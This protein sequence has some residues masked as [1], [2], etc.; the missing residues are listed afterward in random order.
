MSLSVHLS[1]KEYK[2]NDNHGLLI[3]LK[4]FYVS[5]ISD[6][7]VALHLAE[8][9]ALLSTLDDFPILP[10][11]ALYWTSKRESY[12]FLSRSSCSRCASYDSS[13]FFSSLWIFLTCS[14]SFC[15][16]ASSSTRTSYLTWIFS[17]WDMFWSWR[18]LTLLT[19]SAFKSLSS[20]NAHSAK[21]LFLDLS[22]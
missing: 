4:R 1:V 8:S 13:L 2:R 17:L 7:I 22:N 10:Y 20:S 15:F 16:T 6:Y 12:S 14:N 9:S 11:K 3:A 19:L 18:M 21:N 5:K